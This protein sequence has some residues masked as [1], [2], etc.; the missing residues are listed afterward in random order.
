M[1]LKN[2]SGIYALSADFMPIVHLLN[3]HMELF[4]GRKEGSL[5]N[6]VYDLEGKW[7]SAK[8][9]KIS[10][11]QLKKFFTTFEIKAWSGWWYMFTRLLPISLT[12]SRFN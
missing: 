3:W 11:M 8:G 9:K 7:Y 5:Q 10:L 12:K 2:F 4:L 6:S 1:S